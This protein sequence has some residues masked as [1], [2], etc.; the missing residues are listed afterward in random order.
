MIQLQQGSDVLSSISSI[1]SS[2]MNPKMVGNQPNGLPLFHLPSHKTNS[3]CSGADHLGSQ[4]SIQLDHSTSSPTSVFAQFDTSSNSDPREINIMQHTIDNFRRFYLPDASEQ[5]SFSE[6]YEALNEGCMPKVPL[7]LDPKMK[8]LQRNF[9]NQIYNE[10][11]QD[12]KKCMFHC[13]FCK[14]RFL[15]TVTHPSKIVQITSI[16]PPYCLAL[17]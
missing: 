16:Y 3:S 2:C 5:Q 9:M 10:K 15:N 13:P 14:K 17:S 8:K 11:Q 4:P 6:V 7:H 12:K 1:Q